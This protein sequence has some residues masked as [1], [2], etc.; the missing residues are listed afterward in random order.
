M[1]GSK[2]KEKKMKDEEG[3]YAE[4]LLSLPRTELLSVSLAQNKFHF[5]M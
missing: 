1:V 2:L 4:K 3:F 5:Q